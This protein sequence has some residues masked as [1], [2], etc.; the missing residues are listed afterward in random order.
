MASPAPLALMRSITLLVVLATLAAG[1][2]KQDTSTTTTPTTPTTDGTGNSTGG[3][4]VAIKSETHDFTTD[5]ASGTPAGGSGQ[6]A[7]TIP[8]GITSLN[9][10]VRFSPAQGAPGALSSGISVKVGTVTCSVAAGPVTGP[11]TC[12]GKSDAAGVKAIVYS[13]AGPVTAAVTVLGT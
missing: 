11:S 7:L 9:V 1:C 13:G 8:A 12:N 5:A 4:P 3:T 6:T 10:T 2:A